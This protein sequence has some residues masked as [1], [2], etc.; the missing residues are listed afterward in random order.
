[1]AAEDAFAAY[2]WILANT[3]ADPE[4]VFIGGASAGAVAALTLAFSADDV[5]VPNP[6]RF[7]GVVDLWGL[8]FQPEHL[9]ATEPALFIVHGEADGLVPFVAA[10]QLVSRA[11]EV[12]VP[13]ELHAVPGADHGFANV[14]FFT[15]G[16]EPGVTY[17]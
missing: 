3:S 13:L 12:G 1:T 6:P 5:G 16:P 8:I 7:L 2:E 9:E 4:R 11:N 15:E 10:E 17:L 14:P